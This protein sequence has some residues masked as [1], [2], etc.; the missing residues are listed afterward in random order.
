VGETIYPKLLSNYK[1]TRMVWGN[2]D[3][4]YI[5]TL[6]FDNIDNDTVLKVRIFEE[7]APYHGRL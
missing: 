4:L 2:D 1:A 7:G 6:T 5:N 3:Y